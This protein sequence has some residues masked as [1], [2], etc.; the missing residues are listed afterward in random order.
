MIILKRQINQKTR[1]RL[2]DNLQVLVQA[3]FTMINAKIHGS[4]AMVRVLVVGWF[5]LNWNVPVKRQS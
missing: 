1:L 3:L 4:K 2:Y 5:V